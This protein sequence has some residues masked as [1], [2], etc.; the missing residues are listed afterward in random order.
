MAYMICKMGRKVKTLKSC[1][2]LGLPGAGLAFAAYMLTDNLSTAL[3]I[4][5]ITV[6]MVFV[7]HPDMRPFII[8]GVIGLVL[9]VIRL[10][11]HFMPLVPEDFLAGDWETVSRNLAVFLRHRT[12]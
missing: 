10:C 8:I 6:G 3:I 11:R 2:I 12:I 9:I 1:M 7:A 5:G 4:L